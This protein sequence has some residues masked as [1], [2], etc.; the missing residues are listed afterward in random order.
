MC[1]DRCR[2]PAAGQQ[3][4]LQLLLMQ[5]WTARAARQIVSQSR[6]LLLQLAERARALQ[7]CYA[8]ASGCI[9]CFFFCRRS[10]F[11][12]VLRDN[13][14][15]GFFCRLFCKVAWVKLENFII[16]EMKMD[17]KK[18]HPR[19]N[20]HILYFCVNFNSQKVLFMGRK[21]FCYGTILWNLD[22]LILNVQLRYSN[23]L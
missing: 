12:A 14:S 22:V 13:S 1:V 15:Y 5:A 8:C 3:Q 18:S 11:T 17:S 19:L 10:R 4:Q 23:R 7:R 9:C 2:L 6:L 20:M 21:A 16:D